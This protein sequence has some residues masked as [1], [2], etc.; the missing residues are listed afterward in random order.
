MAIWIAIFGTLTLYLFNKIKLPH[1]SAETKIGVG[2]LLFGLLT[3][4]FTLYL[5]PGLW[6]HLKNYQRFYS[7]MT[8]SES[9][10]E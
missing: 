10:T 6:E 4:T 3:L 9:P 2:R 5:I 7:P 1:D 8:Y